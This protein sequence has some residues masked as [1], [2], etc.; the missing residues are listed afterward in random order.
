MKKESEKKTL[1]DNRVMLQLLITGAMK[2]SAT[3][4]VTWRANC[5]LR[6]AT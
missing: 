4:H 1:K 5:Q 2:L 6:T 3:I